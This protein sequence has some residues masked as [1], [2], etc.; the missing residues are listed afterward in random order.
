MTLEYFVILLSRR[1]GFMGVY[2]T[3]N[4]DNIWSV[5]KRF[6]GFSKIISKLTFNIIYLS[7]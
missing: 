4:F 6:K 5:L 2:P 7:T 1:N 3:H